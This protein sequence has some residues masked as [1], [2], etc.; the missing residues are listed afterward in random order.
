MYD[1]IA[2]TSKSNTWRNIMK[3]KTVGEMVE[4]LERNIG[5]YEE[6]LSLYQ[7]T[8]LEGRTQGLIENIDYSKAII[9][10]LEG[11]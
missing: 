7:G 9:R 6:T 2:L 11:K 3:D 1:I 10:E 4:W 8:V 5:C